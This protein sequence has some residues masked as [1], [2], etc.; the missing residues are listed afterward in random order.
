MMKYLLILTFVLVT[1]QSHG[2]SLYPLDTLPY[3]AD[4][5]ELKLET[6]VKAPGLS[7]GEIYKR[8]ITWFAEVYMSHANASFQS[9]DVEGGMVLAQGARNVY[10]VH[11][12]D[13]L[14]GRRAYDY[15]IG[16]FDAC[17][18][19]EGRLIQTNPRINGGR[20]IPISHRLTLEARDGEYR[21]WLLITQ[22]DEFNLL[23]SNAPLVGP[24]MLFDPRL[25]FK[26]NGEE[27]RG[28]KIYSE[29]ALF[30][31]RGL[32]FGLKSAISSPKVEWPTSP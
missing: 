9:I 30:E 18:I 7:Q 25:R 24:N 29:A 17:C 27:R 8:A 14:A 2:Q 10:E 13:A 26:K 4:T 3:H 23:P 28:T 20:M 19:N 22:I 11:I 12:E 5:R 6:V 31:M 21:L 1:L 16:Y 32:Y 15:T